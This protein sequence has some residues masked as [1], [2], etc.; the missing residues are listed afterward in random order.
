MSYRERKREFEEKAAELV[1]RMTLQEA[2]SQLSYNAPAIERL[3]V[4]AYNWWNEGLHGVARGGVATMFPQAIGLAA[5]FDVNV[6]KQ[7]GGIVAQEGRAKY[8]QAA[9]YGDR[10]IFKGLTFWTPNVNIFRD[11]RWGRGQETYGEDP[12]LTS[13][14]A[15]AF[16]C[17]LQG[18]GEYMKAAACAKHF[19]VHSG[20]EA[21]RH[22]FDAEV[23]LQDME[24]TYLPAFEACVTQANVEGVMGAYNRTNGEPCCASGQLQE[25]LRKKWGFEGYFVSDCWAIR[26]FH[27]NHGVTKNILESAALAM[28]KECDLNCGYTYQY[29][30][31][32]YYEGLVSEEQIR[33]SAVRLFTTR[34]RLGLFDETCEYSGIGYLEND[35]TAHHEAALDH[36]RKSMVLLKNDG[37]LPLCRERIRCIAVIGPNAFSLDALRGNYYGEPSRYVTDLQGIQ[38]LAGEEIRVLYSPGCPLTEEK[39][40]L[41]SE[42]VAAARHADVAVFCVGLDATVEGEEGDTGNSFAAGDKIDL[43]LPTIQ[44]DLLERLLETGTPVI[45]VNHTGSAMDLRRAQEKCAAVV[46]AWY[47]GA[48]GG[49]ALAQL[50]FGRYSPSGR[51]PVTFYESADQLPAFEDYSME[52]RTY[53]YFTGR[54]LYPFGYGLS[55]THF[56]Y[57]KLQV[58]EEEDGFRV[59]VSVTNDGKMDGA[60]VVQLYLQYPKADFRTP[61]FALCGFQYRKLRVGETGLL[62]FFIMKKQLEAVKA[63]G[64]RTKLP[65]EYFLHAGG[66]QPDARSCELLGERPLKCRLC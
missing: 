1:S 27:E 57:E 12:W 51:L 37:I 9:A 65:G 5:A 63:D 34:Y 11:P 24:D 45:L 33:R 14:M 4:P 19:A 25:I 13:C 66:S 18:D 44:R 32:A 10:G 3:G 6:L 53:R 60:E 61:R 39:E 55:Y 41:F 56:H 36:A 43:Q 47:G 62:E 22:S 16:I 40:D 29:I 49:R 48:Y 7:M 35:T 21:V 64:S 42:A 58:Q 26:D 59:Q 15:K 17:A 54:P 20:P 31:K 23:T 50:L 46:Q 28:E 38:E 52:N 8:N 2:A 30:M